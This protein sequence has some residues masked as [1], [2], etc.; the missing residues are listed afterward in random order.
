MKVITHWQPYLIWTQS[1][2]T[3][4]MDHTYLL[5]WKSPR[6][7]NQHTARWHS[8][9]QDYHF[10]IQHISGKLHTAADSLLRPPGSDLG[11]DNNQNIQMILNEAFQPLAVQ[12]ANADSNG[13]LE[14]QI[15]ITQNKYT[16]LLDHE[17]TLYGYTHHI[18][19]AEGYMW[20]S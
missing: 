16:Q 2:F 18:N 4:Y 6:K 13:S 1:P 3:I 17:M 8:K 7:L 9:L 15:I 10:T 12:L 19:L 14:H 11:K 5:Y 20:K